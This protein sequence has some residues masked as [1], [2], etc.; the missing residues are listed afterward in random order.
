MHQYTKRKLDSAGYW[1]Q[2]PNT[3]IEAGKAACALLFAVCGV[4]LGLPGSAQ[5]SGFATFSAPGAGTAAGQGT[6]ATAINASGE[7]TGFYWDSNWGR[8]GFLRARN[9]HIVTFDAPGACGTTPASINASGVIA[10]I[11]DEILVQVVSPRHFAGAQRGP[12][13]DT[14]AQ[15]GRD[16]RCQ[17]AD[18]RSAKRR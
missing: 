18:H 12:H 13:L 3:W 7:S 4:G 14:L 2:R 9:G 11:Y 8:H 5:G 15:P 10:G 6:W 16:A 1:I 17:A